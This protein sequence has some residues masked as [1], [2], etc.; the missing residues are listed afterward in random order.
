[1]EKRAFRRYPVNI[2]VKFYCCSSVYSGTVKNLSENGM[3]IDTTEMHFPSDSR[4]EIVFAT[5]EL[6]FHVPVK[7]VRLTTSPDYQ[8]GF[9]VEISNPPRE[10]YKLLNNVIS[11]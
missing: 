6:K 2:N 8:D 4:L 1:M 9:A 3:Y 10:Y 5:D 11:S 7:F